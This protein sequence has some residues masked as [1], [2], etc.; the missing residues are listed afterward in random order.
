MM[1]DEVSYLQ[2]TINSMGVN[3]KTRG[4]DNSDGFRVWVE[5]KQGKSLVHFNGSELKRLNREM[6]TLLTQFLG[7]KKRVSDFYDD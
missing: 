2:R 6:G 5:E 4:L 7:G 3:C 1:P